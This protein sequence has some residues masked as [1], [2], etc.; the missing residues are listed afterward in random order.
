MNRLVRVL[1]ASLV[2][3]GFM[4]SATAQSLDADTPS[5]LAAQI[6]REAQSSDVQASLKRQDKSLRKE[7]DVLM[8][9]TQTP[10]VAAKVQ[11]IIQARENI[12][13]SN[14]LLIGGTPGSEEQL[15]RT[16]ETI[17]S[18]MRPVYGFCSGAPWVNE[19]TH[20]WSTWKDAVTAISSPVAAVARSV[21]VIFQYDDA[22]STTPRLGP[23]AF[24]VGK[25]HIITNRHVLLDYAYPDS[26]GVWHMND[27][28]QVLTV[29][30][31]WEYS[32]CFSRTTPRE[33]R[34][35]GIEAAGKTDAE[36]ADFAILR[37]EDNAL[38]P[39]A[40][41]ADKYDLYEGQKIAVIGY[42][43][44]PLN[45]EAARPGQECA[46]LS[47]AQI[48]TIF[49][50]PNHAVPFPAERFA[51]GTTRPELKT[52]AVMFSYDSST[53]GGNSGS[54]VIRLS[55]GKIVGLH[56]GGKTKSKGKEMEGIY[57]NA[58]KVDRIRKALAEA[59]VTQ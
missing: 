48:D 54:P 37:T 47:E 31:P 36:N 56:S 16:L 24:V 23:T 28:K 53:W 20:D 38:P 32:Q 49:E 46:T 25:S 41:M 17:L 57:N 11:A 34:I 39:P 19:Q 44:R 18:I 13:A 52:D 4:T 40:P 51:P 1:C 58:I 5:P 30:F 10:L 22:Q 3:A 33:V 55:D 2:T 26:N 59:G 15:Q 6:V 43:S 21:G 7:Q 50:L 29:S 12:A 42:P 45:C 14:N 8:R 27:D 35:V 9:A